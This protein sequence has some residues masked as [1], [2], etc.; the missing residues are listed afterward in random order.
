MEP[1]GKNQLR[2]ELALVFR[3]ELLQ[4][5]D[6]ASL[7]ELV[8]FSLDRIGELLES[9]FGF[10]HFVD[11]VG[12]RFS[13]VQ[14]STNS[15]LA[16]LADG[17]SA[18]LAETFIGAE[19]LREPRPLALNH[20]SP[21]PGTP[22]GRASEA[23]RM[24]VAPVC[25]EDQIV[26]LL[27]VCDKSGDY[28]QADADLLGFTA[29]LTWEV[30]ERQRTREALFASEALYRSLV[31]DLPALVCTLDSSGR[32][33]LANRGF[34]EFF[35]RSAPELI[36]AEFAQLHANEE[37]WDPFTEVS[38]AQPT[39]DH[40][41]SVQVPRGERWMR[42]T[43]RALFGDDQAELRGY[44][45]VGED[46]SVEREAQQDL[47]R[48]NLRWRLR[49]QI[50]ATLAHS[51]DAEELLR[52]ACEAFVSHAGYRASYAQLARGDDLELEPG[53]WLAAAGRL[54]T[55]P[56]AF[57]LARE[58]L[59][60]RSYRVYCHL[61]AGCLRIYALPLIAH[62]D[63]LGVLCLEG[64][65]SL[66]LD[67]ELELLDE[68]GAALAHG[69]R[70]FQLEAERD[71]SLHALRHSQRLESIGRLV[72]GLA[73]DLNNMLNIV[74]G[75]A[76]LALEALEAQ[77]PARAKL[78][79][80]LGTS[81]RMARL[82]RTLLAFSRRQTLQLRSLE[83]DSLV[84]GLAEILQSLLGDAITL[85]LAL[86]ATGQMVEAD[87][88]QL[89]QVLIHLALNAR[90]AMPDGGQLELTTSWQSLGED[91]A[92]SHSGAQAGEFVYLSL[93][94]T[95]CG[96]DEQTLARAFEPF[97]STRR[98]TAGEEL[99]LGLGLSMAYGI[100]KQSRGHISLESAL[101]K[102]TT[103]HLYLPR[104]P[105]KAGDKDALEP[106]PVA[107]APPPPHT[108]L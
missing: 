62:D 79:S 82:V 19:L 38:P 76:N 56:P 73:H 88:V 97:F 58:A 54:P 35:A 70:A 5:A 67:H 20:P 27:G 10:C 23:E 31:E 89:E 16:S 43:I 77:H 80:V 52:S 41:V 9:P 75:N 6:E 81:E 90:E 96:M 65:T 100:I 11:S 64:K 49:S 34:C 28:T 8:S 72:G 36:G 95:G 50:N 51:E 94:D 55:E 21:L 69:L 91:F 33:S 103:V 61:P 14:W 45:C 68:L 102:G 105:T 29:D 101:G 92:R 57:E 48:A 84:R 18:P 78:D 47:E 86:G 4:I 63:R 99:G 74:L 40:L 87:P 24:L 106:A 3:F 39:R 26:A 25:R 7:S 108:T 60:T 85:K 12:E 53:R 32:V 2:L 98:R 93:V 1:P 104:I 59:A 66:Q 22:A 13:R 83:L 71:E 37:D 30:V 46:V 107:L 17:S 15:P 42:W 44:H